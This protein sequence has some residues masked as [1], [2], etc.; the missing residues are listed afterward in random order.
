VD[1][2]CR[3]DD[4]YDY[5]D[6]VGQGLIDVRNKQT[7]TR[8]PRVNTRIINNEVKAPQII[9]RIVNRPPPPT[10]AP[11][12][13][14]N[15]GCPS[16]TKLCCQST[17]DVSSF[18]RSCIR[19]ATQSLS[20]IWSQKG[21]SDPNL[22]SGSGDVCG[23][24]YYEPTAGL[25]HGQASPGEF[26][27]V[28]LILSGNN[29]FIGSCAIIPNAA[30]NSNIVQTFKVITAAHKLGKVK[31]E[32][33]L[34]IRVGEYDARGASDH[35][36]F[37]HE[38]YT[39]TRILKHP[40]YNAKR[41]DNDLA[42]LYTDRPIDLESPYVNTACL[43][44]CREQF[45][46]KFENGTGTRCWVAGWGKD[47]YNGTYQVVQRKVDLPL[48]DDATCNAELKAALNNQRRGAGDRFSLSRSEICAG[49]EVGK[50]ACTGDGGSPLVC[51]SESGRWTVVGL[52]TW[53]VG[54]AS[55][56]PGVYARVSHFLAWISQ[57]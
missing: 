1:E 19:P 6:L 49:G 13:S 57:N 44:G 11:A 53:G 20:P 10:A 41:L 34:K 25:E 32:E 12:A 23:T 31:A 52:V 37:P 33:K 36:A 22:S 2:T 39:V 47:E 18:A 17:T 29:D 50:D 5:P 3:N 45:D 9:T 21:C 8:R 40:Q 30:D 46:F 35:E 48:Y 56:I 7:S 42:I 27:W 26:P 4:Y 14:L 43:P 28:C 51:E 24:R 15:D 54:C 38:E 55:D 16:G